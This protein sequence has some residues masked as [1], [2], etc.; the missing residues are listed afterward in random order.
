MIE[1]KNENDLCLPGQKQTFLG[2]SHDKIF[3]TTQGEKTFE[4]GIHSKTEL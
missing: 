4:F 2:T 3:D 1:T